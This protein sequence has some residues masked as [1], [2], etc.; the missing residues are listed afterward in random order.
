MKIITAIGNPYLNE[1]LKYY[2]DCQIIGKDIQYQ[3]GIIEMLEEINDIDIIIISNNL[4]EEY[5]FK[6][7]INKVLSMRKNI[8]IIVFL[9][10]KDNDIEQFLNSKKIYKIYYLN[11][12]GY[13]DFFSKFIKNNE[14]N[15]KEI[16]REINALKNIILENKL[17]N[18][19]NKKMNENKFVVI[20]GESRSR[21][22]Q[23][24]YNVKQIYR[25]A[26]QKS[27]IDR[28]L[29]SCKYAS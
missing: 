1:K 2:K 18:I 15:N 20:D 8:E 27:A 14:K 12:D 19:E 26:K 24:K 16:T 28:V 6:M 23:Y 9:K 11:E 5:P 3:D 13:K 7:L 21:K 10:Y 29:Q 22:N 4:I 17:I 25:K